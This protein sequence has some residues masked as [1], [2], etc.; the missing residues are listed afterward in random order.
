MISED[1]DLRCKSD[2]RPPIKLLVIREDKGNQRG[3]TAYYCL[4]DC[5]LYPSFL[6]GVFKALDRSFSLVFDRGEATKKG[7]QESRVR[8]VV[9]TVLLLL[10]EKE[11]RA[12]YRQLKSF[13][14]RSRSRSKSLGE[15]CSFK[16]KQVE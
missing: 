16:S 13:G 7:K 1:Q 2:R 10:V 11:E 12:S 14:A 4:I 15:N 8:Q 9:E 3:G 6:N 5:F